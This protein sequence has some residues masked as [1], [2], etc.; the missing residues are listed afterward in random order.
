MKLTI[1][2]SQIED[3]KNEFKAR[4][5]SAKSKNVIAEQNFI[6]RC[7][8]ITKIKILRQERGEHWN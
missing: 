4:S 7:L 5:E 8:K 3:L 2:N 1:L 6:N